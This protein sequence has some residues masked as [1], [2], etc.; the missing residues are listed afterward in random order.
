LWHRLFAKQRL[1]RGL[2][3]AMSIDARMKCVFDT[4]GWLPAMS[5]TATPETVAFGRWVLEFWKPIAK[6]NQAARL[7]HDLRTELDH[8]PPT[9]EACRREN[10]ASQSVAKLSAEAFLELARQSGAEISDEERCLLANILATIE[11]RSGL[12]TEAE[13]RRW[14]EAM[15]RAFPIFLKHF[16]LAATTNLSIRRDI[17][18]HPAI[19]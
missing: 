14:S 4:A 16:P 6:A 11:N 8:L 2:E 15:R 1:R 7:V 3:S 19:F 18:C 9:D 17:H 5:R 12:D 10:L 13:H